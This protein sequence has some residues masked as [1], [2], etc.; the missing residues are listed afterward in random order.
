M[1]SI[2]TRLISALA[3]ILTFHKPKDAW[4]PVI[5]PYTPINDFGKPL[6]SISRA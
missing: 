4:F 3:F 6:G 2:I 5:R 1:K